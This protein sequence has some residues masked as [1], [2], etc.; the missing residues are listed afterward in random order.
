MHLQNPTRLERRLGDTETS[1]FLPSRESGVNDMYLHLGFSAQPRTLARD[2]LAHVWAILRLKHPLLAC[3]VEMHNYDDIRFVSKPYASTEAT[4][5]SA[6]ENIIYRQ[7]TKAELI[8]SYLNGPRTLSTERLSCLILSQEHSYVDES[9][10]PSI[11]TE[12]WFDYDLL[13]CTTHFVGDGMALHQC[14]ND[15]FTLLSSKKS[16]GELH[17]ILKEEWRLRFGGQYSEMFLPKSLEE[18]LP[19]YS[20][21]FQKTASIVDFELSQGRLLG[22]HSFPRRRGDDRRTVVPT[23][24]FDEARTRQVL[25]LCKSHNLS[26]SS[27]LFAICN[28]AWLRTRNDDPHLPT[29]MYSALNLRPHLLPDDLNDS[30]WFIAISYFNVVLPGFL[31]TTDVEKTFWHRARSAKEQSTRAAKNPMVIPRSKEMAK[32]R[33]D[34]ARRWAREDDGYDIGIPSPPLTA[35]IMSKPPSAALIGLSLLGNLDGIYKHSAFPEIKLHTLTTGS[36]QRSGAMLLFGYTFV[37]KLW[38]SLGYDEN[39]FEKGI[40]EKFWKNVLTSMDTLL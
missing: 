7:G 20:G 38:I 9:V 2:R 15:L 19:Q 39:G 8:D 4:L 13:L 3:S 17:D 35:T 37:G 22:G 40:V 24:A 23:V 33:G 1:Y 28:I 14:A 18:R 29:M 34:R 31:P 16:T 32:E 5:Y 36:R 26:I 25:K 11:D 30:Y 10:I 27:A 6:N 12:D 21:K